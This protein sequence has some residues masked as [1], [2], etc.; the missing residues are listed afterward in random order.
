MCLCVRADNGCNR[1]VKG[2]N[3]AVRVVNRADKG[4]NPYL[5]VRELGPLC[6]IV[7]SNVR[8]G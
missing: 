3:R 2:F 5:Y 1:A 7:F 8:C 6:G 4:G